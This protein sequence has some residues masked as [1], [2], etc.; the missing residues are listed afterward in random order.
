MWVLASATRH[1]HF[2]VCVESYYLTLLFL[3][4]PFKTE[5]QSPSCFMLLSSSKVLLFRP[6]LG[7]MN[8]LTFCT[9][10]PRSV[11]PLGTCYPRMSYGCAMRH[12]VCLYAV[13]LSQGVRVIEVVVKICSMR[14]VRLK[15][16]FGS[17]RK[18]RHWKPLSAPFPY[19]SRLSRALSRSIR[20]RKGRTQS[21]G[22][23]NWTGE[24]PKIKIYT[25]I[26]TNLG[27]W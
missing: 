4:C 25:S 2:E 22:L 20:Y 9:K 23:Y 26:K 10:P 17:K 13:L 5:Y 24:F 19:A 8:L 11:S 14:G 21:Q 12:A 27:H 16:K 3:L 7:F 6:Y 15:F 18:K 1:R